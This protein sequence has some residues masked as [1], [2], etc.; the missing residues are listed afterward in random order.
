MSTFY[1]PQYYFNDYGDNSVKMGG[2]DD[3]K[4]GYDNLFLASTN[5]TADKS[6]M[7]IYNIFGQCIL[8]N[9]E[10]FGFYLG[11]LSI[12][13]WM[14]STIPQ[15]VLN[16]RTGNADK[17]LSFYFLLFWLA[18]DTCNMVG[19]VLA[20]QLPIQIIT[21]IYYII[22]DLIMIIQYLYLCKMKNPR[23]R[24]RSRDQ[25]RNR[26]RRDS[27]D[28]FLDQGIVNDNDNLPIL[29]MFVPFINLG[30]YD[31]NNPFSFSDIW[32]QESYQPNNFTSTNDIDYLNSSEMILRNKN[33]AIGYAL[34]IISC[35]CY[36]ISRLPQI[37]RN[38]KRGS[39][40][41]VSISMFLLA[42]CGNFL[43]GTSVLMSKHADVP[44]SQYFK[45]HLPWLIGSYG[46]M[47]LDTIIV[48]QCL[49]LNNKR[50]GRGGGYR[51]IDG[52]SEDNDES[53]LRDSED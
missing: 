13:C 5:C 43:Y 47:A 18:G 36:M 3:V 17:A 39:T 15:L 44:F 7:W 6:V 51:V 27:T 32:S 48:C 11:L 33:A 34:G 4:V 20:S 50:N 29:M 42:I 28:S 52:G 37:T 16:C 31:A 10:I 8:S 21:G 26:E 49:Y 45:L 2:S 25:Q 12:I 41:G 24:N 23:N 30:Y 19:C 53:I 35:I 38:F 9:I 14:S 22:M 1:F 46:T 40:Q